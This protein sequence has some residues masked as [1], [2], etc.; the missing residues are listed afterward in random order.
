MGR[1]GHLVFQPLSS[2]VFRSVIGGRNDAVQCSSGP[3]VQCGWP[4]IKVFYDRLFVQSGI[5]M[6]GVKVFLTRV[7]MDAHGLPWHWEGVDAC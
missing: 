6:D 4:D 7:H 3:S 1:L 2:F 5:F